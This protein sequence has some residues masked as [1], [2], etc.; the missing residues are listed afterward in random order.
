MRRLAMFDMRT[1]PGSVPQ[2]SANDTLSPEWDLHNLANAQTLPEGTRLLDYEIVGT[3]GEGGFGIV[4]LAFDHALQRHVAIKEFLPATLASRA[5]ISPAVAVRSQR[6]QGRFDAGLRGFI[7]EARILARFDHPSLVRVLRFWEGNGTAYMAMPYYEGLTLADALRQRGRPPGDGELRGWLGTLLSAL[8]TLHDQDCLHR[9]IAPDNILLTDDG[10]VLLDF[11][12]ARRV[13]DG[14]GAT[15][16]V[17]FKAGFTPIEQFGEHAGMQQGPWTDLYALAAVMHMA[18]TGEPPAPSLERMVNDAYVPL[19]E[20]AR[21][22]YSPPLLAAIDAALALRP[23]NRPQSTAEFRALLQAK[24]EPVAAP[25]TPSER[26][27]RVPVEARAPAGRIRRRTLGLMLGAVVVVAA[28]AIAGY[29]RMA[30]PTLVPPAPVVQRPAAAPPA[31]LPAPPPVAP[32]TAT[33]API[34]PA[35]PAAAPSTV[36]REPATARPAVAPPPVERPARPA[37]AQGPRAP[38]HA[39]APLPPPAP[40]SA[41]ACTEILQRASLGPLTAGEAAFLRKECQR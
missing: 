34:T 3:I 38:T 9:D 11:G 41:S 14:A 4:Y 17:L 30:D 2:H 26:Q 36:A 6:H 21:G 39:R 18:I 15:P 7:D 37:R 33:L 31:P 16:T 40:R 20:R 28:L 23:E 8:G 27:A 25:V 32:P 24:P 22:R 1:V 19:A 5:S 10:P 13:I 29:Q 12:A 35:A